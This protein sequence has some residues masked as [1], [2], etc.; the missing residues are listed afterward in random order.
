[1]QAICSTCK[2]A[3]TTQNLRDGD[4]SI[5]QHRVYTEDTTIVTLGVVVSTLSVCIIE[6][7]CLPPNVLKTDTHDGWTRTDKNHGVEEVL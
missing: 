7:K 3:N 5:N 4:M 2:S 1:M 6:R